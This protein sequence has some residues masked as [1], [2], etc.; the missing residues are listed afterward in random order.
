M[1]LYLPSLELDDQ[2]E[3][4]RVRALVSQLGTVVEY[5]REP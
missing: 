4:D 2:H 5:E 3:R 1:I